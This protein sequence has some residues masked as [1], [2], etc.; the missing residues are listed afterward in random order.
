M[1][2]GTQDFPPSGTTSN[3]TSP[4]GPGGSAGDSC[5][6]TVTFA[7]SAGATRFGTVTVNY[8]TSS[9]SGSET[10]GVSGTGED[11]TYSPAPPNSGTAS[12]VAGGTA[13][14]PIQVVPQGGFNQTVALTCSSPALNTTCTLQPSSVPL[15]GINAVPVTVTVVT[16]ARSGL[17]SRPRNLPP[18]PSAPRV[19]VAPWWLG[20]AALLGMAL[21]ARRSLRLRWLLLPAA[22]TL[23]LAWAACGGG[24]S[25]LPKGTP[26]GTWTVVITGT[27]GSISNQTFLTLNVS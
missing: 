2:A 4:L 27:S 13:T 11:F 16:T 24:S 5:T 18:T 21:A 12:V 14:F 19:P 10:L 22:L 26:A 9:G 7:P 25:P 15:D 3:C 23:V 1:S 17:A 20:L 8:T 6:I